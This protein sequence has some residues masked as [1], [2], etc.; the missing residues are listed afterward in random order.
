MQA[1]VRPYLWSSDAF[2]FPS[3]Y[4]VF[5]LAPLQAAAAG[6]PL[7]V[8]AEP[9][10]APFFEDGRHGFT[11]TRDPASI[12]AALRRVAELE[13]AQRRELGGRARKAAE[14]FDVGHFVER[15]RSIYSELL[16]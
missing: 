13:P 15:W 6:L 9:G 1:D 3:S 8:T 12:A 4:E 2:V 11:I 14:P 16:G 5:S 7:L 10:V